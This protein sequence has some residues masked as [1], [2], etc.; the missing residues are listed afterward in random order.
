M[1]K[2]R[3]LPTK[4]CILLLCGVVTWTPALEAQVF[5]VRT[6]SV[7]VYV[8]PGGLQDTIARATAQELS[9]L[10]NQ[11]VIVVNRPSAGG[12]IAAETVARSAPDGHSLLQFGGSNIYA[13]EMPGNSTPSGYAAKDFTPVTILIA[14]NNILAANPKLPANT[15][16]EIIALAR[17]K[18]GALNYGSLGI[19]HSTHVDVEWLLN[20]AGVKI[21]HIPYKGGAQALQAVASG[22]I[23]FSVTGI[24]AAIPMV[25]QGRI[26][27]V[28]YGGLKRSE[29]FSDMP[30]I[31]EAG[32]PGFDSG[33]WFGW[34]APAATPRHVVDKIA[35]DVKRVISLPAFKERFITSGGHELMATPPQEIGP[36]MERERKAFATRFS[37]FNVQMER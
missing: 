22:E 20:A 5:P 4:T 11:P 32:F 35:A 28:A 13:S 15:L 36:I 3:D 24:T 10:W 9:I 2:R 23:A 6:V 33:S 27:G 30:T 37:Q 8:P 25:R 12:V 21:Q 1:I 26:K 29:L 18:P 14:S 17:A 19:G 34:F 16:Q 7:V 31:A